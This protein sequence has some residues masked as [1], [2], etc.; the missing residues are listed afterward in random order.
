MIVKLFGIL[1]ILAGISL[2]LLKF[3]IGKY[4]ALV[5]AIYLIIKG[6]F[7]FGFASALDI[8]SAAVIII[9]VISSFN[10]IYFIFVAW[11]VQKGLISLFS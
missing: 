2:F 5:L 11:L 7:F 1:D 9:A 8:L 6:I 4:F 3:G 10:F